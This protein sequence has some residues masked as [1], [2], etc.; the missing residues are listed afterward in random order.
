MAKTNSIELPF[1]EPI[2]ILYEDRSVLAIDKPRGWLLVPVN[3]QN[4]NRNLPPSI[5]PSPP[6]I[7]GPSRAIS[8]SSA[9]F[10][11]WTPTPAA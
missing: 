1:C 9:T 4:T 8:S 10:T 3:W 6:G 2:P 5:P 11:A 7:G